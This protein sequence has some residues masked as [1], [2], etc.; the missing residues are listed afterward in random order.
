MA[1]RNFYIKWKDEKKGIWNTH[2]TNSKEIS[3]YY[4]TQTVILNQLEGQ[5][6]IDFSDIAIGKRFSIEDITYDKYDKQF[7]YTITPTANK[8]NVPTLSDVKEEDIEA[9]KRKKNK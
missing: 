7:K 4:L 5:D 6:S 1:K 3:K 9:W 2:F 8:S